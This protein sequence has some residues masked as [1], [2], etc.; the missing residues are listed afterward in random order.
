MIPRIEFVTHVN[1]ETNFTLPEF[2]KIVER[3]EEGKI[4][5]E[6]LEDLLIISERNAKYNR[7]SIMKQMTNRTKADYEIRHFIKVATLGQGFEFGADAII[8]K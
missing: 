3:D 7:D 5:L 6:H 4:N 1:K 2:A 8:F